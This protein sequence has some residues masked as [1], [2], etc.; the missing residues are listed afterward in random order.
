MEFE[1]IQNIDMIKNPEL[2][3]IE[4]DH[5]NIAVKLCKELI[6]QFTINTH[7]MKEIVYSRHNSWHER[8]YIFS[9]AKRIDV[10]TDPASNNVKYYYKNDVKY[11]CCR[12]YT[13]NEEI[14]FLA[15]KVSHLVP[16][17]IYDLITDI[18]KINRI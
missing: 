16:I 7:Q 10:I 6:N 11:Y 1:N 13:F 12:F 4:Y 3:Y 17:I 8:K 5:I 2:D 14:E 15:N 18:F 9:Q